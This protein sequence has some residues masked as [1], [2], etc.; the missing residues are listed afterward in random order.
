MSRREAQLCDTDYGASACSDLAIG[1][2]CICDR[3]LCSAHTTSRAGGVVVTVAVQKT[4]AGAD[5]IVLA[6]TANLHIC[7][8]CINDSRACRPRLVDAVK[9]FAQKTR[10]AMRAAFAEKALAK[11]G[12]D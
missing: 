9:D 7:Y 4:N 8:A 11:S 10:E 1:T 2:C 3:D 12:D 6:A 5:E